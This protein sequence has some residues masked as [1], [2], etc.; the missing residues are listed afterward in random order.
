MHT[1]NV[2]SGRNLQGN[3]QSAD[4][5]GGRSTAAK[6]A[7]RAPGFSTATGVLQQLN[8]PSPPQHEGNGN[9][10]GRKTKRYPARQSTANEFPNIIMSNIRT[11][12]GASSNDDDQI[13]PLQK[14]GSHT[15]IT[16]Y[17]GVSIIQLAMIFDTFAA[18]F[19]LHCIPLRI[20]E[21]PN[22]RHRS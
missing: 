19:S 10:T 9:S 11:G 14:G 6:N 7:R 21:P 13:L 4:D 16:A 15:Y 3:L 17:R 18:A 8:N 1:I 20:P 5:A 12:E 22:Q 2:G